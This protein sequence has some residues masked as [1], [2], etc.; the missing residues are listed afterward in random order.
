MVVVV[1]VVAAHAKDYVPFEMVQAVLEEDLPEH[2]ANHWYHPLA[3]STSREGKKMTPP[4][5][6]PN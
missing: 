1:V 5:R 6:M 4:M 3:K 2:L